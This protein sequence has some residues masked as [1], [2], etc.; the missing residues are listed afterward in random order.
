MGRKADPVHDRAEQ[1]GANTRRRHV[2]LPLRIS[3]KFHLLEYPEHI[4]KGTTQNLS[5]SGLML[6]ARDPLP[7]GSAIT[8]QLL[9]S[10]REIP[11]EGE[12][13]WSRQCEPRRAQ[14]GIQFRCPPDQGFSTQL[15]VREYFRQL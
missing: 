12:V 14:S 15:F 8:L 5:D 6:L 4:F 9:C 1:A 2:R 11:M 10:D 7:P 3:V 13:I